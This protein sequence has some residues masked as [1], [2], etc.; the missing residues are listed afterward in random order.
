ME[1]QNFKQ[2]IGFI[3]IHFE[4]LTEQEFSE[5]VSSCTGLYSN[6][7]QTLDQALTEIEAFYNEWKHTPIEH[8]PLF[9][10]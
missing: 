3:T 5:V 1:I 8:R 6:K 2:L 10:N 7:P 4:E 9:F